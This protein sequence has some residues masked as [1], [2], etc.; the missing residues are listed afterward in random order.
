MIPKLLLAVLFTLC[1]LSKLCAQH[2]TISGQ[3]KNAGGNPLAGVTVILYRS[4][5][6]LLVKT[7]VTDNHGNFELN[8]VKTGRYFLSSNFTGY[9]TISTPAFAI[10]DSEKIIIASQY[11]KIAE[12]KMQEVTITGT[13]QKPIIQVTADKTIFNIESSIN[14]SGSNA[15]ELLQK[16]PGVITDKDDNISLRGKNGVRIYIDGRPAEMDAAGLSGYLKSINSVDIESIE[17]ISNPSASYDAS[18]NAGIINIRLKKN[19]KIGFNGTV[20]AGFNQGI[21]PKTNGALS[22]NYRNK[23][24]NIF[25]NYSNSWGNNEN[26]FD[27]Y[28]IQNDTLYDQK[29]LQNIKG[30]THNIKVGVD[31]F[32]SKKSTLGFI[33]TGNFIDNTTYSSSRTPSSS[34]NTGIIDK[35][36]Y[37]TN[38]IPGNVKNE[39]FNGNY[40]YADATGHEINIDIDHGIYESRKSSYQ[41]N[42]Y[43]TAA[44]ETLLYQ[45]IY[46]N[47]TPINITINTQKI[48]F[49]TPI[50]KGQFSAGAKI[51]NV[52]TDNTFNLYT[53]INGVDKL[54]VSR[55]NTFQYKENINSGYIN[56]TTPLGKKINVQAGFRVENTHSTSLL[57]RTDRT[58]SPDDNI[59]RNY[60]DLFPSAAFTYAVN[61][62][63]LFN[64]NYSRRID[65][66]NYND[67]NPFEARVDELTYIKGNAFL[68]PQYTNTIQLTHTFKS[69]F[70]TSVGYSEIKDFSAYIID[71]TEKTRTFIS[72]QNLASQYIASLNSSATIDI[73]KWWELYSSVNVYNS[74]Y[75]ANFGPGK[76]VDINITSYSL[77]AQNSF[78][79]GK[80]FTGELTGIYNGPSVSAGTFKTK[81]LG[82]M[83]IGLQKKI[84]QDKGTLKLSYTDVLN[85][86]KWKAE[87]IYGGS[88]ILAHS[89][90][91]S[92]Q[93]R[94]NFTYRFGSNQI[95]EDRQHT[96]GSEDE[97]TRTTS[98]GGLN[99]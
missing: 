31:F 18:G 88:Y 82:T 19:N 58:I 43:Y 87:S 90:W 84:F 17:M 81:A 53:V 52:K 7:G 34:I 37:A 9:T 80:G 78:K 89:R 42:S 79:L 24:V 99:N 75:K 29:S 40:H 33:F 13:Y 23:K 15:F 8:Q 57:T 93:F 85:T 4:A 55:S 77:Y 39:N 59:D 65:R 61:E 36:L 54:D 16:S 49:I 38:T 14:A 46:K 72:K 22:L 97:K 25:S 70:I 94:V 3:I 32:V 28:R 1:T 74:R 35:I 67:L 41:P 11:L 62:N 60:T 56:Y 44:P 76:E 68:R 92:R 2:S 50:K 5:D 66:P 69:R 10:A 45:T 71:T 26:T 98:N 27:L 6:S 21:H 63:N 73:T 91:E 95:K 12:K 47:N 64:L 83:D 86:L 30:W 96:P 20:S 48:D 51:S